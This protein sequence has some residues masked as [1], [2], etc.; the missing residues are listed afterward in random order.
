MR[1]STIKQFLIALIAMLPLLSIA[2]WEPRVVEFLPDPV[3]Q[4]KLFRLNTTQTIEA[5]YYDEMINNE[6]R[7]SFPSTPKR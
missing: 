7:S 1:S 5:A 3:D 2:Q 6:A 4:S